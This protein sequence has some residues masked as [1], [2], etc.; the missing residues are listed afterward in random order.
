MPELGGAQPLRARFFVVGDVASTKSSAASP[1]FLTI[2][3]IVPS[4]VPTVCA[5]RAICFVLRE[6]FAAVALG[7]FALRTAVLTAVFF[8]GAFLRVFILGVYVPNATGCKPEGA[9]LEVR[10]LPAVENGKPR[11]GDG[12]V[13]KPREYPFVAVLGLLKLSTRKIGVAKRIKRSD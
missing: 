12:I 2:S 11:R 8:F 9:A 5:P 4:T 3:P 7:L 1:P 13:R 6:T 10:S